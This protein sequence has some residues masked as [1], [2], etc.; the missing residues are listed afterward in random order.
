[1]LS[2]KEIK[3]LDHSSSSYRAFYNIWFGMIDRCDNVKNQ[4]YP[5]YGGRGISVCPEWRDNIESFIR[6]MW[7]RPSLDHSI[8]RKDNDKGYSKDNCRWATSQEQANNRSSNVSYSYNGVTK[9]LA[10][11]C[12]ELGINSATVSFR[13]KNKMSF[14]EAV[15][16]PIK[17]LDLIKYLNKSNT[18][19]GWCKELN[20]DYNTIYGRISG[21]MPFEKAITVPIGE[22]EYYRT[23]M[24]LIPH[25]GEKRTLRNW[26]SVLNLCWSTIKTR[27]RRGMLFEVAI[28]LDDILATNTITIDGISKSPLDWCEHSLEKHRKFK[29]R[30]SSGWTIAEALSG[31][32]N[33]IIV[34]SIDSSEQ[35]PD[36]Q[37]LEFWCGLLG[38]DKE[39]TYL[40]ILRGELFENL[41]KE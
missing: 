5:A 28:V 29:F 27:I 10:E 26:C 39:S 23:N 24:T 11:W 2:N 15:E 30:I 19:A 31:I 22:L 18:L 9:T 6:D 40:R 3:N 7:P 34:Y 13:L 17:Q 38:L 36:T 32:E 4:A 1:M 21:G 16:T 8:D 41:V 12:R 14:K 33:K 37:T 25:A 35:P 20:L